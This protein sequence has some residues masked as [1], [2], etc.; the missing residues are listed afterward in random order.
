MLTVPA[1]LVT[2][3]R[4]N[5]M[6]PALKL[7]HVTCVALSACGFAVRGGLAIAGSERLRARW[8]RIAPHAIDTMLL[9]SA[10]GLAATTGQWPFETPWLTAKLLG[11][12][13]YIA[14]GSVALRFARRRGTRIAAW[15]GALAVLAWIVSVAVTRRPGGFLG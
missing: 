7:L 11:L 8:W 9:A 14:L 12:V 10:L 3:R 13:V 2:G 6:Y 15:L 5:D 4:R 1:V